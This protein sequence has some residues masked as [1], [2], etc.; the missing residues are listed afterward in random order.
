MYICPWHWTGFLKQPLLLHRRFSI[1]RISK[2]SAPRW[3]LPSPWWTPPVPFPPAVMPLCP[4]L[5]PLHVSGHSSSPLLLQS[6]LAFRQTEAFLCDLFLLSPLIVFCYEALTDCNF[7]ENRCL[8]A[9]HQHLGHCDWQAFVKFLAKWSGSAYCFSGTI[10]YS[11]GL[12]P[13]SGLRSQPHSAWWSSLNKR[14]G[15][16]RGYHT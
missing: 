12:G 9:Q 6:L 8:W 4:N 16:L 15:H 10:V 7:V 5:S 3:E 13:I 11:C 2:N 1:P 14:I